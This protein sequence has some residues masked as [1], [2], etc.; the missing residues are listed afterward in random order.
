MN[1]YRAALGLIALVSTAVS[2]CDSCKVGGDPE[3]GGAVGLT[4]GIG[5]PRYR[6]TLTTAFEYRNWDRINPSVALEIN[7]R[8]NGHMHSVLDEWFVTMRVACQATKRLEVGISQGYRHLRQVN[9]FDPLVLGN[10]EFANGFGDL[11]LD[12]KYS[13]KQQSESFPVDVGFFGSIKFPT[14]DTNEH[15]PSGPLIDPENQP[16]SGSWDGTLGGAVSKSWGAWGASAAISYT[17][18]GEGTQHFKAG[19]ILRGT[20]SASKKLSH[21]PLGWKLYPSLGLQSINEF[22]GK[23]N[24]E[25]DRNHGGQSIFVL[26]GISAKP[27]DRLILN[28]TVPMPVYQ[29]YNGTHQKQDYVVHFSV[30]VK[31]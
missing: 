1:V 6:W 28:M 19:D 12:F 16:G 2:A 18:K 27:L 29:E 5:D 9:V 20:L 15:A 24:G 7:D 17:V 25:V 10:H 30:G 21:E 31:F 8:P 13:L 3:R 26:P 14:G 22:K 4:A 11:E 23:V